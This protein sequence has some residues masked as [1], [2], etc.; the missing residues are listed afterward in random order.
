MCM[1]KNMAFNTEIVLRWCK[2]LENRI[3]PGESPLRQFCRE[4]FQGY[5]SMKLRKENKEGFLSKDLVERL[6]TKDVY[7]DQIKESS[8]EELSYLLDVKKV[9]ATVV[10]KFSYYLPEIEVNYKLKPVA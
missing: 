3:S 1:M 5:N 9:I 6:E 2:L 7:I 10:K 8:A 4:N